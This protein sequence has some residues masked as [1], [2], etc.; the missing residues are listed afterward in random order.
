MKKALLVTHVSG[1]VPQFELNN[2]KKVY[3]SGNIV[4][5]VTATGSYNTV[6]AIVG[7][8]HNQGTI[9]N[10]KYLSSTA[11]KGADTNWGTADITSVDS[12][13]DMPTVLEI[14]GDAFKADANNINGGYPLL[15]WQSSTT[16]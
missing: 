15:N 11:T 3:N 13:D 2:V 8:N 10:S 7:L 4:S 9:E 5:N 12:I 16:N 1:F 14:V 6:G